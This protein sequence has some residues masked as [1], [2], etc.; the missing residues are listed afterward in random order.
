MCCHASRHTEWMQRAAGPCSCAP[1][2][3]PA[4]LHQQMALAMAAR[5]V[6]LAAPCM[7]RTAVGIGSG[8]SAQALQRIAA[9]I[10]GMACAPATACPTGQ[11]TVWSN[12][13]MQQQA[14]CRSLRSFVYSLL[15][16]GRM[17]VGQASD[18]VTV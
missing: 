17:H 6:G 11:C 16:W 1:P 10:L 3:L 8:W 5:A 18:N 2:A 12:M 7:H 4:I 9:G 13:H 15:S 14:G